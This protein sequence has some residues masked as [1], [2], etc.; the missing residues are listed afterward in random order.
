M[1]IMLLFCN[2]IVVVYFEVN[3][4]T[5]MNFSFHRNVDENDDMFSTAETLTEKAADKNGF[6]SDVNVFA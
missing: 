1:E 5:Y 6:P 4:F 2:F 3:M